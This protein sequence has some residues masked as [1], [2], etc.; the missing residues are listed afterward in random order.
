[1]LRRKVV[2]LYSRNDFLSNMCSLTRTRDFVT[3]EFLKHASN[4]CDKN[5][6]LQF[7]SDRFV[8]EKRRFHSKLR[9]KKSTSEKKKYRWN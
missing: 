9:G 2:I 6:T 8:F 7:F 3:F 5:I 1:M 4:K